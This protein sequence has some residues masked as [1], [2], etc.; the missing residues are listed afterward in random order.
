MLTKT[1]CCVFILAPKTVPETKQ[2]YRFHSAELWL[3][4]HDAPRYRTKDRTTSFR[5]DEC[6]CGQGGSAL[7]EKEG[8]LKQRPLTRS[9]KERARNCARSKGRLPRRSSRCLIQRSTRSDRCSR[10][11][12]GRVD[13]SASACLA[14]DGSRCKSSCRLA[15]FVSRCR[16]GPQRFPRADAWLDAGETSWCVWLC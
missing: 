6:L 12:G 9:P 5:P 2:T 11:L 8:R 16:A 13:A 15:S 10:R 1:S 7:A 4:S 3:S 14:V